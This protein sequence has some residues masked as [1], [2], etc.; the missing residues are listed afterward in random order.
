MSEFKKAADYWFAQTLKMSTFADGL[1]GYKTWYGKEKGWVNEYNLLE[2]IA[3]I[4]L[5]LMSYYYEVEPTWD[6]CLL[7]S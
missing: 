1:A 5:A 6:E 3:G 7:L 4:E 2:G